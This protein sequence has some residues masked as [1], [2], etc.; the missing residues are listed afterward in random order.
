MATFL[1]AAAPPDGTPHSV[2]R[3]TVD[4]V[5]VFPA[6]AANDSALATHP[7]MAAGIAAHVE[8]GDED[9]SAVDTAGG[10]HCRGLCLL[11]GTRAA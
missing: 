6:L 1:R 2:V 10:A 11:G 7:L 3:P 8:A 5:L 9:E 4:V